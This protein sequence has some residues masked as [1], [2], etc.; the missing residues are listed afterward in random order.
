MA[1]DLTYHSEAAKSAYFLGFCGVVRHHAC[2][3]P[4]PIRNQLG[5]DKTR[6]LSVVDSHKGALP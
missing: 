2:T 6:R 1:H 5:C 4:Q 3:N